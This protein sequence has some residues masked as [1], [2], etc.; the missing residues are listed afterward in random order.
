MKTLTQVSLTRDPSVDLR[1]LTGEPLLNKTI[2]SYKIDFIDEIIINCENSND[3]AHI[4]QTYYKDAYKK[5]VLSQRDAISLSDVGIDYDIWLD[6][7]VAFL[8]K[9]SLKMDHHG[10]NPKLIRQLASYGHKKTKNF[11]QV[12][13]LAAKFYYLK[14]LTIHKIRTIYEDLKNRTPYRKS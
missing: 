4:L 10:D 3:V 9:A 11:L 14:Y 6:D 2:G 5:E 1:I 12:M 13:T 7:I 8:K